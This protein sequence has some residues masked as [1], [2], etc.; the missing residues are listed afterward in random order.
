[1]H[2]EH[3]KFSL[4]ALVLELRTM[5]CMFLIIL[6]ISISLAGQ[7]KYRDDFWFITG[8]SC[9]IST[10]LRFLQVIPVNHS[11]DQ[12]ECATIKPQPL[13]TQKARSKWLGY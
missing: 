6:T 8:K 7:L 5:K 1:M 9:G 13:V 10:S 2:I 11:Q 4:K 3:K 12:Y